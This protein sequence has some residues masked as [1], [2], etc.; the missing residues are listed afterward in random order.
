[1]DFA[2]PV[3]EKNVTDSLEVAVL[4]RSSSQPKSN[5]KAAASLFEFELTNILLDKMKERKSHLRAY[6]KK[7]L[8]DAL[9]SRDNNDKDQDLF[10]GS[11]RGTKRRKSSKEA[12]SSRYSSSKEKKS[13]STSKDASQFQHKHSGKS[14]HAEEPSHTIDDSGVQQ[15][16]EF[17]MGNNDEPPADKEVSKED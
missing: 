12:E 9:R 17:D 13:S 5:Y 1:L 11:D 16:Q 4:T 6:Y 2:N 14:D 15:D 3:I 10:A 7:K 8:Y